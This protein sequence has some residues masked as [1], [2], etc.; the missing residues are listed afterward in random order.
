MMVRLYVAGESPN[1]VAAKGNLRAALAS[2]SPEDVSIEL[3]DVLREPE[4][5]LRDGVLVTP[6]L[7]RVAPKP[8]RRMVGNLRDRAALLAGLGIAEVG[9]E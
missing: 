7:I 6:T 3:V 1:S 4:R 8:E 5:S 9:R 2:L